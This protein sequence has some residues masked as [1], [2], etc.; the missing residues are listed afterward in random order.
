MAE[1]IIEN[2]INNIFQDRNLEGDSE[3]WANWMSKLTLTTCKYCL[4]QHGKIV[5][6][7]LFDNQYSIDAHPKCKCIY[8]PMRTK[9]AGTA[10]NNGFNGADIYLSAYNMLPSYYVNKKTAYVAGWKTKRKDLDE[11]L[12]GKM[13]GGDRYYNDDLKLPF[14]SGRLWYEADINYNGGKRNGHR[15]LYSNDGL[16]FVTYDHYQTF[17]EII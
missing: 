7:S 14:A 5:D 11:V 6:I 1:N 4:E 3:K 8:V 15:I 13:I 16:I 9:I 12:P 10:T 17:Y 2:L